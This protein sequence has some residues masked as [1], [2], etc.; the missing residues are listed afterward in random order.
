MLQWILKTLWV[1]L[2][3]FFVWLCAEREID[4]ITFIVMRLSTLILTKIQEALVGFGQPLFIHRRR[5]TDVKPI[6][7]RRETN[8]KPISYMPCKC[9]IFLHTIMLNVQFMHMLSHDYDH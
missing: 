5:E 9:E 2:I 6:S 4:L 7:H 8:V 3:S 1:L